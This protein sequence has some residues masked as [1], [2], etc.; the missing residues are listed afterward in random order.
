LGVSR[1][2]NLAGQLELAALDEETEEVNSCLQ[3]L[4][5]T[6]AKVRAYF[7]VTSRAD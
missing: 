2:L 5:G 1:P 3:S 4:D 7:D 6:S